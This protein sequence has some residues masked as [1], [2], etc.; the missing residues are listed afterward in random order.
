MKPALFKMPVVGQRFE[1][2]LLLH[3]AERGAVSQT[4]SFVGSL[5]VEV[6]CLME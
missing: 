3:D 2:I 1:H 6:E 5:R 4:P